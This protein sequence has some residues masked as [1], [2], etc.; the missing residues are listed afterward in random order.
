MSEPRLKYDGYAITFQEVPHEVS[1]TINLTGCPH[2]C[3]GCHSPH[4]QED[5]GRELLPDLPS[6]LSKYAGYITCVCLM[7]DGCNRYD[8]RD[9][10]II[11][12]NAGYRICLYSGYG[13]GLD[14]LPFVK[15]L[16][17]LKIGRYDAS[18]G[19]LNCKTTNQRFYK[20]ERDKKGCFGE[21]KDVTHLFYDRYK[22]L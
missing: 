2:R 17:Y 13:D 3:E 8:L 14:L 9:A 20:I 18:R 21:F 12:R 5:T 16:D 1:L 19:G 22:E 4:L 10:L 11:I 15:Y 6:L 7:G